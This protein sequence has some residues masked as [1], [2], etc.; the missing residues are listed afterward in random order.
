[1]FSHYPG[2]SK[3]V[4]TAFACG[5]LLKTKVRLVGN[6]FCPASNLGPLAPYIKYIKTVS[7]AVVLYW[8]SDTVVGRGFIN[9]GRIQ[10][11]SSSCAGRTL[12]KKKIIRAFITWIIVTLFRCR[13][14]VLVPSASSEKFSSSPFNWSTRE[15]AHH[16]P[17]LRLCSYGREAECVAAKRTAPRRY[18]PW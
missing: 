9:W 17:T 8:M 16:T 6:L 12:G 7:P 15:R 1:M 5:Y 4:I 18:W 14:D 2:L 13:P 11:L 10:N 3:E